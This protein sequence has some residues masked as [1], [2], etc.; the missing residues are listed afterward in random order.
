MAVFC[1]I[2]VRRLQLSGDHAKRF[3]VARPCAA[4]LLQMGCTTAVALQVSMITGS[5]LATRAGGGTNCIHWRSRYVCVN[6][7]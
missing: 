5:N 6:R 7:A 4:A 3:Q 1:F 2:D